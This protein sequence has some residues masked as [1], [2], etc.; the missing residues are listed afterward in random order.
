MSSRIACSVCGAPNPEFAP[1]CAG[2]A[3][4]LPTVSVGS[5]ADAPP[6]PPRDSLVGRDVGPYHVVELVGAGAAGVV[7]RATDSRLLRT[8][9][10]K[11][12]SEQLAPN[13]RA[14]GRMLREARA[15]AR[16]R[17]R[18]VVQVIEHGVWEGRP[19]IAME[20]LEGRTLRALLDERGRLS[21]AETAHWIGQIAQGLEKA[22]AAGIVHR[23]LK[24]ENV[25]LA[26]EDGGEVAKILD[27]GV[28]KALE[29]WADVAATHAGTLLGTPAYMSPEQANGARTLDHR[30][31]LWSLG[32]IAFECLAGRR[33][34]D[35][36]QLGALCVQIL[37]EPLPVPTAIAPDV[38][39]G[40]DA[41]WLRAASRDPSSRFQSAAELSDALADAVAAEAPVASA[42]VAAVALVEQ[43]A[44][45]EV[46]D[47]LVPASRESA[48]PELAPRAPG[49]RT[50]PLAAGA[51]AVLAL[52]GV[53]AVTSWR[54]GAPDAAPGALPSV[55]TA[56]ANSPIAPVSESARVTASAAVT[57]SAVVSTSAVL[58]T[59][60][61]VSTSALVSAPDSSVAASSSAPVSGKDS[62]ASTFAQAST[63]RGIRPVI[64]SASRAAGPET[65]AAAARPRGAPPGGS[66]APPSPRTASIPSPPSAPPPPATP[67]A[68]GAQEG[69]PEPPHA[70]T[71]APAAQDPSLFNQR[72]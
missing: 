16:L 62:P 20:F 50:G 71:G 30:S 23:D 45:R 17:S 67:A 13:E 53:W 31:D 8:V 19:Y 1:R 5:S 39:P 54:V 12:L 10:L 48:V 4:Y 40:F 65:G 32:V 24:P 46:E 52:A 49:R 56:P 63:E 38:P 15:A 25:L 7:Y 11:V 26:Q 43:D 47:T 9:A 42:S 41:W 36:D 51:F 35:R 33:P 69:A 44:D 14:R 58:S 57:T 6:P 22:H 28:A 18:H 68:N 60:A 37:S 55:P 21:P 70:E 59:S 66:G 72:D 27:F 2:C 61:V 29:A 64:A 34:F 3:A